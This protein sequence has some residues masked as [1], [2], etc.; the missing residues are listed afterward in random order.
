MIVRM[1]DRFVD[2]LAYVAVVLLF[3]VMVG[4]GLDVAARYFLGNPI[5]WMFEFVQHSL[6]LILFLG[7]PWLTR[8]REHIAVDIVVDAVPRPVRRL[9]LILGCVVSAAICG[10]LA[11]WSAIGATDN[12]ARNVVTDGIYPIPR[13]LLI[14]AIAL[15]LGLTALE[16]ARLAL[17]MI[18]DPRLT[19][20]SGDAELDSLRLQAAAD[21]DG[22]SR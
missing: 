7:L 6:L 14:A 15:G 22:G 2:A 12:F 9:M 18:R 8:Q 13:G 19:Q 3:A 1:Y 5:G 21:I 11:A 4:I 20:R 16:F 17:R 10:Y